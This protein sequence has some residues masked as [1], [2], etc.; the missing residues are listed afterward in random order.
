MTEAQETEKGVVP[1]V[2]STDAAG[3]LHCPEVVWV[4]ERTVLGEGMDL[5]DALRPAWPPISLR[6]QAQRLSRRVSEEIQILQTAAIV[7]E[8]ELRCIHRHTHHQ[9]LTRRPLLLHLR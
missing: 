6:W 5:V 3:L 2:S 4:G 1:N 9:N 8:R 7:L